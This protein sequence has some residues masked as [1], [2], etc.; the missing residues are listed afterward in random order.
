M[1]IL[2][3]VHLLISMTSLNWPLILVLLVGLKDS[4]V[5]EGKCCFAWYIAHLPQKKN[6]VN[7]KFQVLYENRVLELVPLSN[8]TKSLVFKRKTS[9]LYQDLKVL[10]V[11]CLVNMCELMHSVGN[12]A[13][14]IIL[15]SCFGDYK[16]E[17]LISLGEV[18]YMNHTMPSI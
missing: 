17:S 4:W 5:C 18:G 7:Y 9:Q 3:T 13:S 11:H 6:N 2:V 10:Y 16:N 14:L 8:K 1:W 12:L 15:F